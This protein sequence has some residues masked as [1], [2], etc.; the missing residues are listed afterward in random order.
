MI[1]LCTLGEA[2]PEGMFY[3]R[4]NL[5]HNTVYPAKEQNFSSLALCYLLT[6]SSPSDCKLFDH[7]RKNNWYVL[8]SHNRSYRNVS[9]RILSDPTDLRV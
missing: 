3:T 9:N 4:S 6:C 2:D 5:L 7:L 8:F 1:N